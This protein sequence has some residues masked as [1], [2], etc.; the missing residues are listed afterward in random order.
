MGHFLPDWL[1]YDFIYRQFLYR[2]CSEPVTIQLL[3]PGTGGFGATRYRSADEY[4][5]I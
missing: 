3:P 2:K 4:I 1:I 5:N